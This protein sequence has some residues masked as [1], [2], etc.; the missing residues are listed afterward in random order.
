MSLNS[1]NA[2]VLALELARM[3]DIKDIDDSTLQLCMKL[4]DQGVDPKLLADSISK[5]RNET[6]SIMN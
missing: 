4:L 2:N 1:G 5:I 3:L 6:A